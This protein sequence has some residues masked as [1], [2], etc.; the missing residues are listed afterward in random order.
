MS[1]IWF[2]QLRIPNEV[3]PKF[4]ITKAQNFTLLSNYYPILITLCIKF[5]LANYLI[6]KFP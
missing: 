2:D 4:G 5:D 6:K 3:P 1:Y